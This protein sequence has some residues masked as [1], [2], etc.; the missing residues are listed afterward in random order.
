MVA[1]SMS[2][3]DIK[4]TDRNAKIRLERFALDRAMVTASTNIFTTMVVCS[5]ALGQDGLVHLGLLIAAGLNLTLNIFRLGLGGSLAKILH[6]QIT[7]RF[8]IS[9]T[10]P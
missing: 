4:D 2:K 1:G 8:P 9:I 5:T 6:L 3:N 10:W 7:T